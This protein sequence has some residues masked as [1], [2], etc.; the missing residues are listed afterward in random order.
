MGSLE[1]PRTATLRPFVPVDPP[2]PTMMAA[3][4]VGAEVPPTWVARQRYIPGG[5][6]FSCRLER[7]SS[8]SS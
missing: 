3:V 1:I 2:V 7:V 5:G 6:P 8:G 4:P